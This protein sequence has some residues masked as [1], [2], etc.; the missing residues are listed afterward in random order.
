MTAKPK[1][2]LETEWLQELKDKTFFDESE[3]NF[4]GYG[5]MLYG[6]GSEVEIDERTGE[7]FCSILGSLADPDI[8]DYC[9][10]NTKD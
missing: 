8:D 9:G 10:D 1:G 6:F 4:Y 7:I 3:E 2:Y 5:G